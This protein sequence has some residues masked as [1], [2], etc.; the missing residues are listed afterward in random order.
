MLNLPILESPYPDANPLYD[1]SG[2]LG[3]GVRRWGSRSCW[4]QISH[5]L[6]TISIRALTDTSEFPATNLIVGLPPE[7]S[8]VGN[9]Q[10]TAL[11][12]LFLTPDGR[13]FLPGSAGWK[14]S[15]RA[16]VS[17]MFTAPR[18]AL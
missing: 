5:N 16:E 8:A 17:C 13:I 9:I 14:L 2:F 11:Q 4:A 7:L 1:I 10:D 18:R 6:V 15:D 3:S 12:G